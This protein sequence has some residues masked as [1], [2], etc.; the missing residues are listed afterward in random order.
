MYPGYFFNLFPAFPR[1]E[2]IFV[3]MSFSPI[4][5]RRWNDVIAPAIRRVE[6]D[7]KPLEPFRV[8]ARRVS[9]SILTEILTGIS[10]SRLVFADITTLGRLGESH[11]R[12]AN[13]MYE[14]GLAHAV[15]LPEEVLL[16]RSDE[17]QLLFDVANIRINRYD[18]DSDPAGAIKLVGY[19]IIEAIREVDLKKNLAVNSAADSLDFTSWL[20][21]LQA[22][23]TDGIHPPQMGTMRHIMANT[24]RLVAIQKLLDIGALKTAYLILS[25]EFLTRQEDQPAETMLN[26]RITPFGKALVEHVVNRMGFLSPEIRE[27]FEKLL[28]EDISST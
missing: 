7:G 6:I 28:N 26:Y 25:S 16:F 10:K 27:I 3:A 17:D 15:R 12:N 22:A 23:A 2:K 4:L 24:K 8:D 1:E 11:I 14:V 13:V 21:L 9:D 19:S 18:P 5:D 20:I